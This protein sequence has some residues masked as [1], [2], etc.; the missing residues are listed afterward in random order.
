M[1]DSHNS[2]FSGLSV[3]ACTHSLLAHS[4]VSGSNSMCNSLSPLLADIVLLDFPVFQSYTTES[5][6]IQIL[7]C[8]GFPLWA[9]PLS[10]ARKRFSP[11]I[12]GC[13][14]LL[15]NQCGILTIHPSFKSNVIANTRSFLQSMW[16]PTKSTPLR[17]PTSLL[18]HSLVFGFNTIC[19]SPSPLLA[20]IILIGLSHLSECETGAHLDTVFFRLSLMGFPIT[21]LL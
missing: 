10:V 15:P 21:C 7:S 13:F 5:V 19:N 17:G 9:F 12:K 8:L 14:I 4:P 6:L 18:A 1:W 16:D 11:T 20:N 3:I 2:P